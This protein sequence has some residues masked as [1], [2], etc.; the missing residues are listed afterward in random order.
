MTRLNLTNPSKSDIKYT[1]SRF[2]DGEV[3]ITLGEINRKDSIEVHCRI[4]N[5]EELFILMQVADILNRHE[6]NW[7]L[8]IYYLMSMR[9]DRVMD[10]N[11]PFTLKIVK[12]ILKSLNTHEIYVLEPHSKDFI[13]DPT[14]SCSEFDPKVPEYSNL[15]PED[16]YAN[17]KYQL[18]APDKGA[19][20]RY[21][22]WDRSV[23]VVADKVRNVDTGKI[24][25]IK[26]LN[27]ELLTANKK[28]L[29]VCDDLCDGGGTFIG[30]ANEIRKYTDK[31]LNIFVT[32]MVNRKGIENLSKVYD[33]VYFT[34][35]YKNW[36]NLPEN[37]T[38]IEII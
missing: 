18:I 3:Q 29:L 37:V 17:K 4:T 1:I 35:S 22:Y 20:D 21:V 34:N 31:E 9:M 36:D 11:R 30:L 15:Y 26:I 28:P 8:R 24:E 32:H 16:I 33:H 5:A 27:P 10:F 25:S 12:N 6:V 19:F 14:W 2:P 23:V 7:T 13:Y 38:Q